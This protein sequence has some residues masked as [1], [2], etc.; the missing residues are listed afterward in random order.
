MKFGIIGNGESARSFA[1]ASH[2]APG[3]EL[4]AIA[5]RSVDRVTPLT[6]KFGGQP[7]TIDQIHTANVDCVAISTPPGLHEE[8][9]MPLIK[10]GISV[11]I[12]KP[13]A[14]S[15]DACDRLI[16]AADA[17]GAK[18]M[19][20]QT[21]RYTSYGRAARQ[22]VREGR[23]GKVL[24][25]YAYLGLDYFGAKR[26]GW[27]LDTDMSGGGVV[28]NP[29]IHVIDFVRY[30]ADSEVK[31][32]TGSVGYHKPEVNIDG[33]VRCLATF[34][35]GVTAYTHVDG[36]GHKPGYEIDVHFQNAAMLIRPQDKRIEIRIKGRVAE[37][38]GF[39]ENGQTSAT[40]IYGHTG[41]VNHLIEIAQVLQG[42]AAL[43]SDGRNGKANVVIAQQL[44]GQ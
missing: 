34:E 20:T 36:Y 16:H 22:I 35:N 40:G 24:N 18:I 30:M 7:M 2:F 33:D 4:V 10:R 25:I 26:I 42:K 29:F 43:T 11:L 9:A 5:G 12:E 6:E 37:V 32:I 3:V 19:V 41:Y 31:T 23:F 17:S 8:H 27:H 39:G 21:H 15:A 13:M 44:I 1:G 38:Y 28:F 14:L